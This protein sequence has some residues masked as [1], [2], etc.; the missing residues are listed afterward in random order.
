VDLETR[1][2]AIVRF[3]RS[4]ALE[5]MEQQLGENHLD[6]LASLSDQAL[7]LQ[8]Q[9]KLAEA[10]PLCRR[11]LAG[12]EQQL[13]AH[14]QDTLLAVNNLAGLLQAQGKLTEAETLVRRCASSREM[15]AA[16]CLGCGTQHQLKTCA[17]CHV[18]RFCSTVCVTRTWPVHKPNCKL[19]RLDGS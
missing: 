7:L 11:A 8:A 9:G 19:W 2:A 10:E 1:C 12:L 18:A 6:T 15:A 17:K 14:H 16:R 3:F 13:G 4:D 5:D